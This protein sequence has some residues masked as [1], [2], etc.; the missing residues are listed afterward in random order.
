M[1]REQES[2]LKQKKWTKFLKT[3][4]VGKQYFFALESVNDMDTI[5]TLCTRFNR[6]EDWG[7]RFSI[8]SVIESRTM[9]IS[10]SQRC[11]VLCKS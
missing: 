5:A 8:K 4:E 11:E 1:T 3:L 2:L 9:I 10:V 7:T 6:R